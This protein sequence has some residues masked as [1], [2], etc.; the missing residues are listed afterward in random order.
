[1]FRKQYSQG[2]GTLHTPQHPEDRLHGISLIIIIQKVGE[3]FRI[4]LRH[5][6]IALFLQILFQ[7]QVIFNDPVMHNGNGFIPVKM[8]MRIFIA[9]YSVGCPSCMADA[10]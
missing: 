7:L 9:G 4:R 8:R 5:E 6:L 2:V 3:H 1:M 10:A